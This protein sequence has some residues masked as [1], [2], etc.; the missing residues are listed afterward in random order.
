MKSGPYA[1]IDLVNEPLPTTRRA[2]IT[3]HYP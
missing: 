2:E 1:G 3:L